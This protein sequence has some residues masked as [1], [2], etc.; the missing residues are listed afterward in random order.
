M[1]RRDTFVNQKYIICR[2][3]LYH[4]FGAFCHGAPDKNILSME[5]LI[6]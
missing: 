2:A 6:V 1:A 3:M 5:L 4:G